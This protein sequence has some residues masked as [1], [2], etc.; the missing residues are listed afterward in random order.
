MTE[1]ADSV[2]GEPK[3]LPATSGSDGVFYEMSTPRYLVLEP[4]PDKADP[5]KYCDPHLQDSR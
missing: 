4:P 1:A 2:L 5:S 3:K